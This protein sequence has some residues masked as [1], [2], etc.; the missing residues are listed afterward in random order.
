LSARV[1]S[2]MCRVMPLSTRCLI[3]VGSGRLKRLLNCRLRFRYLRL[4][5]ECIAGRQLWRMPRRHRWDLVL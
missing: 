2:G 3:Y 1:V 5:L 4:G